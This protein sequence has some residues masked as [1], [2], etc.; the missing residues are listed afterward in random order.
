MAHVRMTKEC[1]DDNSCCWNIPVIVRK[2]I[3]SGTMLYHALR[4][5]CNIFSD[6]IHQANGGKL[7]IKWAHLSRSSMYPLDKGHTRW[8]WKILNRE[9]SLFAVYEFARAG[10]NESRATA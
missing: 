8:N 4:Y 2:L 6:I 5:R 10:D 3:N 9:F 1:C 7:A